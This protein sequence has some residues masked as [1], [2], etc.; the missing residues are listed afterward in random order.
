MGR[1]RLVVCQRRG[2]SVEQFPV[3]AVDDVARLVLFDQ[4][5]EVVA[6]AP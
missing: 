3:Q 6:L 2:D 5:A 4:E 1:R